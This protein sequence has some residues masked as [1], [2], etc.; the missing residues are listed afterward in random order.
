L[1]GRWDNYGFIGLYEDI[2][3]QI[4]DNLLE[5]RDDWCP[6]RTDRQVCA[7]SLHTLLTLQSRMSR[8]LR[9]V[10]ASYR[11]LL[12]QSP[13]LFRIFQAKLLIFP[14]SNTSRRANYLGQLFQLRFVFDLSWEAIEGSI[15]SIRSLMSQESDFFYTQFLFLPT[16]CV[17]LD[18][19][20][21]R[22]MVSA[23]LAC[24]FLRLLRRIANGDLPMFF[25]SVHTW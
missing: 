6:E 10:L 9:T 23:D 8:E 2:Q 3:H 16:I 1:I 7:P 14:R 22:T 18:S 24:G 20:Y 17:E 5:K 21:P 15:Y 11:E 13:Q 12:A 25:G 4:M 19:V